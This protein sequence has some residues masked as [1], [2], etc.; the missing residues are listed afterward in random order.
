MT[1]R[2]RLSLSGSHSIRPV[3]RGYKAKTGRSQCWVLLQAQRHANNVRRIRFQDNGL[4]FAVEF[5]SLAR[6]LRLR[7]NRANV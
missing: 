4:A 1:C 7:G 6:A 3:G 2:H 5:Q